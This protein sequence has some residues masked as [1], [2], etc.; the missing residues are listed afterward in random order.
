MNPLPSS[1]PGQ[2]EKPIECFM[3]FP[4]LSNFLSSSP[5]AENFIFK[6]FDRLAARS[7]LYYQSE[8]AQLEQSLDK[9]DKEEWEILDW[10]GQ[11]CAHRWEHFEEKRTSDPRQK[12]RWNIILRARTVLREYS[13]YYFF[14]YFYDL[15]RMM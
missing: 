7:L 1:E 8:L 2:V 11:E 14:F 15:I 13:N 12:E 9:L 3:G 6:R 5:N 4:A 10:V